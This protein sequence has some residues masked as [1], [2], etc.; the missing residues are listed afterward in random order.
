MLVKT[1]SKESPHLGKAKNKFVPINENLLSVLPTNF[2]R[3]KYDEKELEKLTTLHWGQRKLFLTELE[4]LCLNGGRFRENEEKIVL[5]IGAAPGLH[6]N[7]LT[8]LFP[9]FRYI[10]YDPA[11][12]K[13]EPSDNVEIHQ[14][15]FTT[16]EAEKYINKNVLFICDIRTSEYNKNGK[17]GED[18][19]ADMML[20]QEWY[21]KLNPVA[22]L[23]KFR[24]SYLP[25]KTEYLD[26]DIYLQSFPGKL[27]TETRLVPFGI[28]RKRAWDHTEYEEQMFYHNTINRVCYYELD[29]SFRGHYCHCY[30]CAREVQILSLYSSDSEDVILLKEKLDECLG[31]KNIF[32]YIDKVK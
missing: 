5:Y 8:R 14:E 15:C 18:I 30:D 13:I 2:P 11:P 29:P 32:T 31:G 7:L 9:Q 22:G 16:E 6:L 19:L 23:L 12:F 21:I 26:G 25:G 20:Q 10:L 1:T 27:S 3:K 24:F 17:Q 28:D 4:F